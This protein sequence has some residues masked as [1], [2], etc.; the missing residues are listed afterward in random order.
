MGNCNKCKGSQPCRPSA[1]CNDCRVNLNT[2]CITYNGDVLECSGIEPGTN[3][4]DVIEQ[5]DEKICATLQDIDILGGI[6]NVGEGEELYAGE[7]VSGQKKIKT[8]LGSD[9]ILVTSTEEEVLID[10]DSEWLDSIATATYDGAS[11]ANNQVGDITVGYEL[12]GMTWQEIVE[13]MLVIYLVPQLNSLTIQGQA[14]TVEVGTTVAGLKNF[15]FSIVNSSNIA[16]DTLS[17]TDLTNSVV[18]A[19]GLPI[20][21]PASAN[22]GSIQK[23]LPGNN[24]WQV[25]VLFLLVANS[26]LRA[27]ISE[28]VKEVLGEVPQNRLHCQ[29]TVNI[30]LCDT[31]EFVFVTWTCH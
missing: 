8:I 26:L 7:T 15:T 13:K 6:I 24:Q 1:P 31:D 17:V 16:P 22:V 14:S 23:V 3:L 27:S 2:N 28:L 29:L 9:E 11:P 19:S 18:L 5:L 25:Q 21:S 10:V 12:T 30:L 20:A 4:N